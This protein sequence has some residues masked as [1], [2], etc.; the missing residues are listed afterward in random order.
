[1]DLLFAS[2]N[3][4]KL[5]EI[6]ELIPKG[7]N[8][9]SLADLNFSEELIES[10]ETL[11]GNALQKARFVYEKF[12]IDCFADDS[13]LEVEGLEG[14]PG[15]HSAYFAGQPKNDEK[16]IQFLLS[17]MIGRA[18]RRARFRTVI[19]LIFEGR[20]VVFEGVLNGSISLQPAGTNGFG[21]DPVFIAEGNSLT[22]AQV[23]MEE[24]NQISHRALAVKKLITYLT[25]LKK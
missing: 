4:N 25:V 6:R 5:K 24:K 13:G 9:L 17:E 21:Y 19:A 22:L 10:T 14:R 20:E 11:E 23:S 1:M 18:N 3:S 12:Q 16:N 2:A 8:L 7:Y 15:V